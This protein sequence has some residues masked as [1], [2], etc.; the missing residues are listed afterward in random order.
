MFIYDRKMETNVIYCNPCTHLFKVR[1]MWN[2]WYQQVNLNIVLNMGS[3]YLCNEYKH[4]ILEKHAIGMVV[5][6]SLT[7][8]DIL[9]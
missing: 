1:C 6:Y 3:L 4:K 5:M 8:F 9:R 2:I 7:T